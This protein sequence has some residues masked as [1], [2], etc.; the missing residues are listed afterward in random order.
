[1]VRSK[2]LEPSR[3]LGTTT[4]RLRVYQFHHERTAAKIN[5]LRS[6]RIRISDALK[7]L[8]DQFRAGN[9]SMEP[10]ARLKGRLRYSTHGAALRLHLKR[11]HAY[12]P[13]PHLDPAIRARLVSA[14]ERPGLKPTTRA[15]IEAAL[16]Q[17]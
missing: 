2:G 12:R 8:A 6:L 4:S 9:P 14:L 3:L 16:K 11:A 10:Y 5:Y 7:W 1:M 13:I 15:K 17:Q